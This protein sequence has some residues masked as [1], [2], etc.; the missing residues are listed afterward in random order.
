MCY[1]KNQLVGAYFFEDDTVNWN[2]YLSMLQNVFIWEMRKLH[3]VRS[4]IFQQDGT[5]V[6][7]STDVRQ[8]LDNYF[9]NR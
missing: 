3:K 5:P 4:V 6:H 8:H 1:M 7:F 2:N 9:P